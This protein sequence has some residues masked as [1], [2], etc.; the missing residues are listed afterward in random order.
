[1]PKRFFEFMSHD[2]RVDCLCYGD[3][4]KHACSSLLL[5]QG[6]P[7]GGL[8]VLLSGEA[9]VSVCG[10]EVAIL[11]PGDVFG[12]ISFALAQPATADVVAKTDVSVLVLQPY[13]LDRLIENRPRLAGALYRSLST[14]LARRL[15]KRLFEAQQRMLQSG[16]T[17][18]RHRSLLSGA[19]S[20]IY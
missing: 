16:S 3:W 13:Q 10:D 18:E 20:S 19:E 12:E 6:D 1:V 9:M 2:E 8:R 5:K 14:E 11:E 7:P 4:K 17:L 15:S